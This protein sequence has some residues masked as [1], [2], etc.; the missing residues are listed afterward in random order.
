MTHPM[1]SAIALESKE[2]DLE[3]STISPEQ[4]ALALANLRIQEL[5]NEFKKIKESSQLR[6]EFDNQ[7]KVEKARCN[8]KDMI[9]SNQRTRTYFTTICSELTA[10]VIGIKA[11]ASEIVKPEETTGQKVTTICGNILSAV[12]AGLA[13]SII[14]SFTSAINYYLDHKQSKALKAISSQ[15][16]SFSAMDNMID[17][18][19]RKLTLRYMEQIL[20]MTSEEDVQRFAYSA[21]G[22]MLNFIWAFAQK[23]GEFNE[24]LPSLTDAL[25]NKVSEPKELMLDHLPASIKQAISVLSK[26]AI[27]MNGSE[28]VFTAHDIYTKCGLRV[29]PQS[30]EA[31]TSEYYIF[32]KGLHEQVGYRTGSKARAE[33]YCMLR[34]EAR[35]AH[36]SIKEP[37]LEH[38]D[39]LVT[40]T[41]SITTF[42]TAVFGG[43]VDPVF[44]NRLSKTETDIGELRNDLKALRSDVTQLRTD[45]HHLVSE[46]RNSL[47]SFIQQNGSPIISPASDASRHQTH[48]GTIESQQQTEVDDKTPLLTRED[49]HTRSCCNIM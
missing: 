39:Y 42:G 49:P 47:S 26:A 21:V 25:V 6:S 9:L 20:N 45:F 48:Y 2:Q 33:K 4:K 27:K 3:I 22:I 1:A 38:L 12:T 34:I 23:H 41:I 36:K 13:K 43:D 15:I 11:A 5:E 19:A 40:S 8:Q 37:P 30:A 46:I 32:E 14:D 44:L 24:E 31:A 17:G 35:L 18:I 29:L 28:A 16:T 7:L 10:F